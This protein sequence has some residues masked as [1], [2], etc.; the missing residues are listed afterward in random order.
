M[1]GTG[2]AAPEWTIRISV[3]NIDET[4]CAKVGE[5]IISLMTVLAMEKDHKPLDAPQGANPPETSLSL[6]KYEE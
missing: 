5:N 3:A 1:P 2:F 4:D 6:D